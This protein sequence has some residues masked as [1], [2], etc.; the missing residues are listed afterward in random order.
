MNVIRFKKG[1]LM[2]Q[3]GAYPRRR[4]DFLR[5]ARVLIVA[6]L[7]LFCI[8]SAGAGTAP[9]QQRLPA[10]TVMV[11][12]NAKNDLECFG[13][14]NFKQMA[15]V[16]S[17]DDVNLVVEFGRPTQHSGSC[18]YDPQQW[19]G[20]LRFRVTKGM[21]PTRKYSLKEWPETSADMGSSDTLE[22]FIEWSKQRYPANHYMLI[23]WSH[24]QGWRLQLAQG[25]S[26]GLIE[27]QA[28][29]LNFSDALVPGGVRSVSSDDETG[30]RLFN[31]DISD[32]LR[33]AMDGQAIDLLGFDACL[34]SMIETGYQMRNV[35][36]SMVASEELESGLGWNYSTLLRALEAP[37]AD[38]DSTVKSL[39]AT[40]A[41]EYSDTHATLA[42]ID[43]RKTK[44][45]AVAVSDWSNAMSQNM[46]VEAKMLAQ[47]R[48]D[49]VPYG[50]WYRRDDPALQTS[51]DL[52]RLAS[53]DAVDTSDP[54][55]RAAAQKVASL[56]ENPAL[57]RNNYAS[58][59]SGDQYGYGSSGIAIYFPDSRTA[60]DADSL[61]SSGY[62]VGNRDHAV[63]F[64]DEEKWA[65]FLAAY[66]AQQVAPAH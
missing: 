52:H 27:G 13:L 56:I 57:V 50:R 60:F 48:K 1:T 49:C 46:P 53:L 35:A 40:F 55:V 41:Q 44:E 23:I 36:Q 10:W 32:A 28:A 45:L 12:M 7:G 62:I 20:V 47:A 34:M 14:G 38:L 65:S 4:A 17:T 61:N 29:S 16:G 26:A 37:G 21:L 22:D 42:F 31:S 33:K 5:L 2:R 39:K 59:S 63:I 24:G 8:T 9:Q 54:R 58:E 19:S 64:V 6:T 66:Y 30:H 18:A 51:I 11:Y 15:E 43:L 25:P 3:G